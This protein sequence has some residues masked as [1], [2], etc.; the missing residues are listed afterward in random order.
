M[1]SFRSDPYLWVHLAGLAALPIFLE[2][3][4]VGLG[5][6]NS[7]MP[8]WFELLFVGG[9]GILPILW[10]QWQ[11]PFSIFSLV[12]LAVRPDRLSEDQRKVLGLFKTPIQRVIAV[13]VAVFMAFV[14]WQLY[15]IAPIAG[16]VLPGATR[17]V[18][19]LWAAIAF[20]LGNLFIQ[21]PAS[22]LRL[23]LMGDSNFAAAPAYP[24]EQIPSSFTL[25]G[26][27]VNQLLPTLAAAPKKPVWVRPETPVETPAETPVEV[28]AEGAEVVETE[29]VETEAVETEAVETEAVET[30]AEN[31][32]ADVV[33]N[34]PEDELENE[35]EDELEDSEADIPLDEPEN[36][37]D[38]PRA[39]PDEP[40]VTEVLDAIAPPIE[41]PELAEPEITEVL[42]I[43]DPEPEPEPEPETEEAI[44]PTIELEVIALEEDPEPEILDPKLDPKTDVWEDEVPKKVRKK[45]ITNWDDEEDDF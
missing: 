3:C 20:F 17:G 27:R 25:L 9:L 31:A 43:P 36:L 10:M 33:T 8:V 26:L 7:L 12:V 22:V 35:L 1:R 38:E 2:L 14:L 28:P 6:G 40:E 42:P 4:L 24:I 29:A 34:E 18:G 19:L 5:M 32:I 13:I 37:P 30:E 45:E 41:E 15:R 39:L 21:V 44:A 16:V 11:K 23:L